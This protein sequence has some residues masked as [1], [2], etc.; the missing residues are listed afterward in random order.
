MTGAFLAST[1]E[2]IIESTT[3]EAA[4][5]IHSGADSQSPSGAEAEVKTG[6]TLLHRSHEFTYLLICVKLNKSK[7]IIN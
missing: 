5:V 6:N 1:C 4:P 2:Y 3:F 7:N